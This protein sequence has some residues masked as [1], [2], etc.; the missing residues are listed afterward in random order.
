MTGNAL[1]N[2]TDS[3]QASEEHPQVIHN[4]AN[5]APTADA[6]TFSYFDIS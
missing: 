3:F 2:L 1:E 4:F 6:P 5:H